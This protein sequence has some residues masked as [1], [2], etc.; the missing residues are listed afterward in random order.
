VRRD[1]GAE[2]GRP[3][4]P[5][6]Q[7]E[8]RSRRAVAAVADDDAA[9]SARP[10]TPPA[11]SR[12]TTILLLAT[13]AATAWA[14]ALP[15]AAPSRASLLVLDD[16]GAAERAYAA[17]SPAVVGLAVE[18]GPAGAASLV[19]LGSGTVWAALPADKEEGDETS[20]NYKDLYVI[21]TYRQVAG[22][23]R[24]DAREAGGLPSLRVF[25]DGDNGS[26][27]NPN[28]D[29]DIG[30]YAAV[31]LGL[32]PTRDL[33]VLRARVPASCP[34]QPLPVAADA[35]KPG[36]A[37]FL[38]ARGGGGLATAAA[39]ASAALSSGVVSA[40]G[41]SAPAPS[42]ARLYG[43]IQTDLKIGAANVGGPLVDSRGRLVGVAV[44][45]TF[46]AGGGGKSGASSSP[47]PSVQPSA[48]AGVSFALASSALL[49]AVPNLAAYGN[50]AGRV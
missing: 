38:L 47:R 32:D 40:V 26:S 46:S 34:A 44:C 33:A 19:P 22:V 39:A 36:Q 42:G 2:A 50:A 31:V 12:R 49:E 23:A 29:D 4:R 35:P 24:A 37:V 5:L 11:S 16:D 1:L 28:N 27:I 30:P 14:A 20:G 15:A 6:H 41:R 7:Q 45:P 43:A 10:E 17:A 21:A 25:V 18:R 8:R 13:T 9:P 3:A 48:S